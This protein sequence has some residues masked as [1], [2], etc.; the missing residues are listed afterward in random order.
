MTLIM[1]ITYKDKEFRIKGK[2]GVLYSRPDGDLIESPDGSTKK[3][4]YDTF[5]IS[6]T[7][8]ENE[9]SNELPPYFAR[10]Y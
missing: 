9:I 5:S 3:F 8:I 7:N 2:A 1:D 10:L 6:E 4:R